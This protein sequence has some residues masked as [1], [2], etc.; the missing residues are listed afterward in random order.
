[1][2]E[3]R[4]VPVRYRF[5]FSALAGAGSL[6]AL[7]AALLAMGQN[8][9]ALCAGLVAG[10][11]MLAAIVVR[12]AQG[13]AG[14]HAAKDSSG[15]IRTDGRRRGRSTTGV[16]PVAALAAVGMIGLGVAAISW[17][18]PHSGV[19]QVAVDQ[20]VQFRLVADDSA[21]DV[22]AF[23]QADGLPDVGLEPVVALAGEDMTSIRPNFD[24]VIGQAGLAMS[25][26]ADGARARSLF[27]SEHVGRRV[28]IVDKFG[29]VVLVS[30]IAGPIPDGELQISGMDLSQARS[31]LAA[32]AAEPE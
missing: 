29:V 20:R 25:F 16:V 18:P 22:I 21:T 1:M 4:R 2:K 14:R 31:L 24:D 19:K 15:Q 32:L 17:W 7:V 10:V 23:P 5:A 30:A 8:P 12:L 13:V 28:A 3:A 9:K 27:T 11:F 26:G 6:A